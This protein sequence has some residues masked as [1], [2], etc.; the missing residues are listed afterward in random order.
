MYHL[1]IL[2][3]FISTSISRLQNYSL[4]R[5]LLLDWTRAIHCF[6]AST[7]RSALKQLQR[8]QNTAARLVTLSRKFT[9]ITPVLKQLHWL[10]IKQRI[11]F[12]MSMFVFKTIRSVSPTCVALLNYDPIRGNMRSANKLLLSEHISNNLWGARS[13]TVSIQR[14]GI[15]LQTIS[16]PA[17]QSVSSRQH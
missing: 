11:I 8:F 17:Q 13:F 4:T 6:T 12:K 10:P 7:K 2:E 16:E 1:E 15:H 14:P 5:S 3:W 9:H